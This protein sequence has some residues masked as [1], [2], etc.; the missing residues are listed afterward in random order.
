MNG[1]LIVN[2][3]KKITQI[4]GKLVVHEW[5][6]RSCTQLNEQEVVNEW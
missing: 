3:R 4:A 6:M 2:L 1:K 5:S